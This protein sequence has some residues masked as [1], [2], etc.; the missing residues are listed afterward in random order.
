MNWLTGAGTRGSKGPGGRVSPQP[1]WKYYLG[2]SK[3][4]SVPVSPP[5]FGS[6]SGAGAA[7]GVP[8]IGVDLCLGSHGVGRCG[9]K[10]I[11]HGRQQDGG[12]AGV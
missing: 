11:S 9:A 6:G 5:G 10:G 1:H 8:A 2:F 4:E 7:A 12:M 3:G